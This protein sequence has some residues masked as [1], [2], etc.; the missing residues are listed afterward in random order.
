MVLAA[1]DVTSLDSTMH[2]VESIKY[3]TWEKDRGG[4][5]NGVHTG[6]YFDDNYEDAKEDF[7]A[8][9]GLVSKD[10]LFS[11]TERIAL[12][13]GI[14]KLESL[15]EN[16]NDDTK[17]LENIKSKISNLIPDI[18]KR[19]MSK[20]H[21]FRKMKSMLKKALNLIQQRNQTKIIKKIMSRKFKN[22]LRRVIVME[23][24]IVEER[25]GATTY[26]VDEE[27][28][29]LINTLDE[30]LKMERAKIELFTKKMALTWLDEP[31]IVGATEDQLIR[32]N[33]LR[34]FLGRL[35]RIMCIE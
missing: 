12:Y 25:V 32:I 17:I 18:E 9:S 19:Y 3:V 11:E 2:K 8:R 6:H 13:A 34:S 30:F 21:N 23:Y 10:K 14:V 31:G 22:N 16:T 29:E 4:D 1:C 15:G 28:Y 33:D 20:T 27:N 26:K 35:I 7:A 5:G 24:G